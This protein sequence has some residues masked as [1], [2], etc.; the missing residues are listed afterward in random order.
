[1]TV[2]VQVYDF[3][4]HCHRYACW[5]AARAASVSRFSNTQIA[6]FIRLIQLQEGVDQLRK[7][8]TISHELYKE[9]FL[10]KVEALEKL[11]GPYRKEESESEK[12]LRN[13]SFG[14]AAKVISVY[15]KTY[16]VLP[17]KGMSLLSR[18]AF[19]PIDSFL[20]KKLKSSKIAAIEKTNWSKFEKVEFMQVIQLLRNHMGDSPF[21]M[22]EKYWNV[23]DEENTIKP[24][25]NLPAQ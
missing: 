7:E 2:T 8:T 1:M 9:W 12:K 5:A 15:V 10:T 16:E 25:S 3:K 17:E 19:P 13:I 6:D 18:F 14:I 23:N 24:L 21:W 11:M 20:L 4:E 22:L